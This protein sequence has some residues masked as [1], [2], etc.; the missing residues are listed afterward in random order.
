M[1]CVSHAGD[2]PTSLC[3]SVLINKNQRLL[4]LSGTARVHLSALYAHYVIPH[5]NDRLPL[6]IY[7]LDKS[8]CQDTSPMFDVYVSFVCWR[9]KG[10][11]KK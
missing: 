5:R 7:G 3:S 10:N 9:H 4:Y 1:D 11:R 8:S 2:L 6:I